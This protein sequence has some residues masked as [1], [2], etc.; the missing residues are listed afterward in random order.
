MFLVHRLWYDG[1]LQGCIYI[2]MANIWSA[3]VHLLT[4][5]C[6]ISALIINCIKVPCINSLLIITISWIVTNEMLIFIIK[7]WKKSVKM[8][9]CHLFTPRNNENGCALCDEHYCI[10]NNSKCSFDAVCVKNWGLLS[11]SGLNFVPRTLKTY[12]LFSTAMFSLIISDTLKWCCFS[13]C[14]A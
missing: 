8:W 13:W 1:A 7:P 10:S 4:P 3:L 12:R 9:N 2:I 11:T 5:F 14:G 6:K